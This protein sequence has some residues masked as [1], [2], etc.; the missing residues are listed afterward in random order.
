M[1]PVITLC[2][3]VASGALFA[4]WFRYTCL[5]ILSAKTA[6]DYAEEVAAANQLSFLQIQAQLGAQPEPA[7]VDMARLEAALVR[8]YAVVSFLLKNTPTSSQSDATEVETRMLQVDYSLA[9]MRYKASRHVS[10]QASRRALQEMSEVI[11][12]FAN[13]VGERAACAAA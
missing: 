8:D 4:Y 11:A 12:H 2:L 9:R 13:I 3:T 10:P 6:W 1:E 5:L 7:R